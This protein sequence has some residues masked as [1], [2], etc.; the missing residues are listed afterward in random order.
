MGNF[1]GSTDRSQTFTND[2]S[3]FE[4]SGNRHFN[5]LLKLT[6]NAAFLRTCVIPKFDASSYLLPAFMN[7]EIRDTPPS[8]AEEMT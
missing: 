7:I 3:I 5:K 6:K 2:C 4:D 8:A 1:S